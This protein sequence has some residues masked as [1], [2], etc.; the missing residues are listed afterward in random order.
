MRQLQQWEYLEV[1]VDLRKKAWKDNDGRR[2]KL[3]KGSLGAAL[4]DFGLEGWELASGWPPDGDG[5]TGR[6]IFKRPF[7]ADLDGTAAPAHAE[8]AD[9]E[10]AGE[11]DAARADAPYATG[12]AETG[13]ANSG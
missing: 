5:G 1:H 10:P 6:L 11:A 7:V 12:A 4:N 8:P 3:K 2:G 9:A 13:A